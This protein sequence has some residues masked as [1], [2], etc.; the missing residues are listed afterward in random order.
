MPANTQRQTLVLVDARQRVVQRHACTDMT[1][2]QHS[3]HAQSFAICKISELRAHEIELYATLE[4]LTTW[5]EARRSV[6]RLTTRVRAATVVVTTRV[7]VADV[8][9]VEAAR[10]VVAT[11]AHL[12]AVDAHA[13]SARALELVETTAERGRCCSGQN[14]RT[15][16]CANFR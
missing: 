6:R 10:T 12:R 8:A 7:L 16:R 5:T 13:Q 14:R 2:E 11:V 4:V 9:L 15:V 3:T 1:S